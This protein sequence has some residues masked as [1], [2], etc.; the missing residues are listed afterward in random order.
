MTIDNR[1]VA[2]ITGGTDGLGLAVARVF[3]KQGYRVAVVGRDSNKIDLAVDQLRSIA[4]REEAI[5][6][7]AA[8]VTRGDEVTGMI[9]QIQSRF[10]RLD[11]LINCVGKSDRGLMENLTPDRVDELIKRN[12]H[13]A[14]LC[15]QTA[16]PLL[17][18]SQ[19][20]IVNIGSLAAKVGA[21]YIGGYA[22]AKHAVAGMS[23]QLR[24][25]LAPRGV[26]VA[27]VNPGPIR[28]PDAGSRYKRQVD[29]SLPSQAAEPGGGTRVKG[30]DPERVAEAVFQCVRRRRPDVVLPGYLRVLIAIGHAAPRIGDW[31]LLKFTSAGPKH[32]DR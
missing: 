20:V 23:Q 8:D 18:S 11:V 16:L 31:L 2:L 19:G 15:S 29:S 5:L 30:L 22:I 12:V 32:S 24:L 13:T 10:G 7:H 6:G 14:L 17:E 1:P 26:H 9:D 4:G 21:R 28:R 3:A 25:E 27:L